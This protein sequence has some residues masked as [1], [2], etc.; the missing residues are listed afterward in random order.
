M[1]DYGILKRLVLE[2]FAANPYTP[3]KKVVKQVEKLAARHQLIPSPADGGHKDSY[4]RYYRK[5]RL[6]P[7]D[8]Q[9]VTQI[10]WSLIREN[11]LLIG[12][13]RLN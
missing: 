1:I 7:V 9:N 13:D 3:V 6:A 10:I 5:K 4:Q 11:L 8:R 12:A 2:V